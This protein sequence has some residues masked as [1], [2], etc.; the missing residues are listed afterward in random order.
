[1]DA[2]IFDSEGNRI[3]IGDMIWVSDNSTEVLRE[4]FLKQNLDFC[5]TLEMFNAKAKFNYVS[6]CLGWKFCICHK[7]LEEENGSQMKSERTF[8]KD[9]ASVIFLRQI[10]KDGICH[11]GTFAVADRI[12]NSIYHI[13]SY[14][15]T[16]PRYNSWLNEKGYVFDWEVKAGP[17]QLWEDERGGQ[18]VAV[19]KNNSIVVKPTNM[20]HGHVNTVPNLFSCLESKSNLKFKAQL[21]PKKVCEMITENIE[22][23]K[24]D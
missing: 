21:D 3:E 11:A 7:A 16:V 1:M 9:S 22:K 12:N 24:A 5:G 20:N 2:T 13:V 23:L 18:F 8:S 17:W 19:S 14:L 4:H 15:R 10:I 6:R